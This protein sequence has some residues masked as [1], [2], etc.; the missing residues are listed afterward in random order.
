MGKGKDRGARKEKGQSEP[1]GNR[2]AVTISPHQI[3][4][5]PSSR[6]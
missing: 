6:K 4:K 3:L 1:R 2:E 5:A